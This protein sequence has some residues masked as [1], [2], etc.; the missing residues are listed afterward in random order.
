ME[1][2]D[3]GHADVLWWGADEWRNRYPLERI[4]RQDT[5]PPRHS[6]RTKALWSG[7]MKSYG[8]ETLVLSC[9]AR[10]GRLSLLEEAERKEFYIRWDQIRHALIGGHTD[11]LEWWRKSILPEG[12]TMSISDILETVSAGELP[13]IRWLHERGFLSHSDRRVVR[14]AIKGGRIEVL[15]WLCE[16]GAQLPE[17]SCDIAAECGRSDVLLWLMERGFERTASQ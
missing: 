17:S 10:S 1:A 16:Q 11:V 8:T 12:L 14:V 2:V 6:A 7:L 4:G 13:S 3:S 15:R 9:A 5:K